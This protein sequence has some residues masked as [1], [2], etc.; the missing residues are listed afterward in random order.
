MHASKAYSS[1]MIPL[2]EREHMFSLDEKIVYPGH[3][4]ARISKIVEKKLGDRV[5]KFFELKFINKDMTV[6]VPVSNLTA[7]GIRKLCSRQNIDGIFALLAEPTRAHTD[8][9]LTNWNK[10]SKDYQRRLRSGDLGEIGVIYRNLHWIATQKELSFGEKNLLNQT[11]FL[12]AEEISEVKSLAFDEAMQELR[13]SFSK[14]SMFGAA[15]AL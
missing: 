14:K 10:R 1:H 8:A 3:G 9:S 13:A 5:E 2:L 15:K 7:A 12:L 6:L 4:V 11:E